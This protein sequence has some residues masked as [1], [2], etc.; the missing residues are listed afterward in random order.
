MVTIA[1]AENALKT[2]YLGVVSEQLNT[3]V[4]PLLA[5]IKQSTTDVWGKEV[6]KLVPYGANGGIGAGTEDG[7]LP[8]PAGNNY[9]QFQLT[10]KNLYGTIEISD[11]AMRASAN[12][13]GRVRQSSERGNGRACKGEQIQFRQNAFRRRQRRSGD[14]VL[15]NRQRAYARQ[16]KKRN[17]GH[18]CGRSGQRRRFKGG[19]ETNNNRRQNGKEHHSVGRGY[20]RFDDSGGRRN[21][22]SGQLQQGN[23]GTRRNFFRFRLPL[24]A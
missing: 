24:R 4:N 9:E 21:H 2:L 6:R 23:N 7:L 11:K 22:R 5:K 20:C 8:A 3:Q 16:R 10:L 13:S 12:N 19:F 14:G 17:G 1:S 18:G 15:G